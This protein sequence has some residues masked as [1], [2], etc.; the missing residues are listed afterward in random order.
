MSVGVRNCSSSKSRAVGEAAAEIGAQKELLAVFGRA[1][2]DGDVDVQSTDFGGELFGVEGGV[3]G[4]AGGGVGGLKIEPVLGWQTAARAAEGD[5]GR[6][7]RAERGPGR[8]C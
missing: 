4:V 6:R 1:V 5:A 8:R 7:G 3:D 2:G